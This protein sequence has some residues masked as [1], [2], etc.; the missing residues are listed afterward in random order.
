MRIQK[1]PRHQ[2]KITSWKDDQGFGFI[3]PNG[4]GPA[5]FAIKKGNHAPTMWRLF[6]IER[7]VKP[8]L[9]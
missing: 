3:A 7:H 5:V 8:V 2:G 9:Q 6:V 4:G 1:M